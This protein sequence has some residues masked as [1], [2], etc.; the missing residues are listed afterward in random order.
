MK[1]Y[2]IKIEEQRDYMIKAL[3]NSTKPMIGWGRNF[4]KVIFKLNSMIIESE[5]RRR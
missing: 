2:N 3:R 1:D 4:R 5:S